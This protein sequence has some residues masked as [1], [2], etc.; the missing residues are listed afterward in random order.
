MAMI[1]ATGRRLEP[2]QIARIR[3][4]L[5]ASGRRNQ[6][7]PARGRVVQKTE[8]P[9]LAPGEEPRPGTLFFDICSLLGRGSVA[10]TAYGVRRVSD[11][12]KNYLRVRRGSRPRPTR[13]PCSA[14]VGIPAPNFRLAPQF[15]HRF[16]GMIGTSRKFTRV[17]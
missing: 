6:A 3:K 10:S 17:S 7:R 16:S 13:P 1:T 4:I 5:G 15:G 14:R 9:E 12:A 11:P 2:G 8:N